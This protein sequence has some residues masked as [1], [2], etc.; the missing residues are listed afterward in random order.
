VRNPEKI[1]GKWHREGFFERGGKGAEMLYRVVPIFNYSG[2]DVIA[3]PIFGRS[4]LQPSIIVKIV[5]SVFRP[6]NSV[7]DSFPP[8]YSGHAG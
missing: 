2:A 6:I 5:N 4:N 3:R 7:E 1:K 8:H